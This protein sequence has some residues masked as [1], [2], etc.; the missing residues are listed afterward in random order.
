[1][2]SFSGG[3]C[4][5]ELTVVEEYIQRLSEL[6]P[7]VESRPPNVGVIATVEPPEVMAIFPTGSQACDEL[8]M[9]IVRI[10]EHRVREL[11][12]TDA[13]HDKVW[14]EFLR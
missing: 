11:L 10:I 6:D 2:A 9:C 12:L 5:E 7:C 1:M 14:D 13:A 3:L 8:F 4:S